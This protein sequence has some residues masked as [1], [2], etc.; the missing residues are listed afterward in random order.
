MPTEKL[1]YFGKPFCLDDEALGLRP[2]KMF[3][4]TKF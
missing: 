4:L 3:I 2:M 1:V